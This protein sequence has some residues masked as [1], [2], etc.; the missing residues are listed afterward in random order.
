MTLP[1]RIVAHDGE[2]AYAAF[3]RLAAR[4]GADSLRGFAARVGLSWPGTIAGIG[5]LDVATL[6]GQDVERLTWFSPQVD[7]RSRSVK[8]AG[9]RLLLNDWSCRRRRYCS[10]CIYDDRQLAAV[11][12]LQTELGPWHRSWWDIRSYS[13][14]HLHHVGLREACPKCGSPLGWEPSQFDRCACGADICAAESTSMDPCVSAYIARRLGLATGPI[15]SLLEPL[16]LHNS[17]SVL[18]RLGFSALLEYRAHRPRASAQERET[19]RQAGL[20][21]AFAWPEAFEDR[22][23]RLVDRAD[24]KAAPAGMIGA[25]GWIYSA[26][27][28][29]EAIEP[30]ATALRDVLR[31]HAIKHG[32]VQHGEALY[33]ERFAPGCGLADLTRRLGSSYRLVRRAAAS[34]GALPAGRRRGV[35]TDLSKTWIEE[36]L[37]TKEDML[38]VNEVAALLGVGR[39]R[40]RELIAANL[41]R[42]ATVLGNTRYRKDDA[43]QLLKTIRQRV[44]ICPYRPT[45]EAERLPLACRIARVSLV[46][47]VTAILA[48]RVTPCSV[49][50]DTPGLDGVMVHWRE[51]RDSR[52][53][54]DH[55]SVEQAADMLDIHADSVRSLV[56]TGEIGSRT[57][58]PRVSRNSVLSFRDK[59]ISNAEIATRFRLS[60]RFT[61]KFFRRHGIDPVYKPPNVRNYLFDR[62][63][64][65]RLL[66]T[67]NTSVTI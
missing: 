40:V 48:G 37:R 9:E 1:L 32:I 41:L 17:L 7:P 39:A 10:A 55:V 6:T 19:A 12:G 36:A 46:E 65:E 14:C 58:Q 45:P 54:P 27:A 43:R 57:K 5:P 4:H 66:I 26:W 49:D 8:L 64:V 63:N 44:P 11:S 28:T 29:T 51:L 34:N 62:R 67:S 50:P 47:A 38:G 3:V 2:P 52:R 21:M 56:R 15:P 60:P 31:A 18:A 23:D 24:R 30:F 59:Y 33:G 22:L 42:P 53:K 61:L 16:D 20:A 13:A 25:Y 35:A